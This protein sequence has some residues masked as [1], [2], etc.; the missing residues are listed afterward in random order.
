MI[1]VP[2][3]IPFVYTQ[4]TV[5]CSAFAGS[6]KGDAE[7]KSRNIGLPEKT[8]EIFPQDMLE[9]LPGGIMPDRMPERI[10]EEMSEYMPHECPKK[11][12]EEWQNIL[13]K[14]I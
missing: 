4:S 6:Q 14:T 2:F 9:G 13:Q 7:R 10:P 1:Q 5:M 8:V 12:Q 3:V 11:C